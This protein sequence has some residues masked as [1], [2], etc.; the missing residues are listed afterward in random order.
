MFLMEANR[1]IL[2]TGTSFQDRYFSDPVAFAHD[3]IDFGDD[4]GLTP[5]QAEI[6][7]NLVEKRRAAVRGPHGLGKTCIASIAVIWFALT[8]DGE[9]WKIPTTAS[10]WRQL[11][12]FLWPEIHKWVRKIRWDKVQRS[13]FNK[14]ELQTLGLRLAT[15][16]AFAMASSDEAFTEGAHADHLLY[17]FDEAKAIPEA[18]FDAA[19]G[20]L[21]TGDTYALAISTPGEPAGRFY[22]IHRRAP[23]YEDWWVRHVTL[24]ECVAANRITRE[25]AEQRRRQ[26]GEE[27][28]IYYNRVLGEFKAS[29]EDAVVPLAWVEAAIERWHRLIGIR[30]GRWYWRSADGGPPLTCVGVDI[31]RSEAGDKTVH[32]HRHEHVITKLESESVADTMH[33]VGKTAGILNANPE[34]YANVDVIGLGGGPVDRLRE[35]F[36]VKRI[37]DFNAAESAG[38]AKDRS[39]ELQFANKRA[40]AWWNLRELLDPAYN[41]KVALP[42]SDTMIGDLTTPKR[43]RMTSA[44]KLTI[45]SKE[46]IRKRIKRSTNEGD[47]IVQSFYPKKKEPP[48]SESFSYSYLDYS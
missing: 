24:D 38:N 13:P 4:G 3:C 42:P 7:A 43:G 45:E 35:L 44:G 32:A 11:T 40:H 25:Q 30:D 28:A 21:M 39:G 14:N 16:H 18:R 12:E 41:S 15:G 8:R 47:A 23:G 48:K 26:W 20:A 17:L 46:D 1:R 5:Y 31:S 19:E 29:D 9:D 33:T 22:D 37:D 27:S 6:L 2:G 34:A 36:P 10:A